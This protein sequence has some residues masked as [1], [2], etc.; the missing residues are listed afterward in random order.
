MIIFPFEFQQLPQYP[1]YY[2]NTADK[3]VYSIKSGSLK[4]IKATTYDPPSRLKLYKYQVQAH[5]KRW[6][7]SI[8]GVPYPLFM[9][10]I[11]MI[12]KKNDAVYFLKAL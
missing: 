1:G 7:L 5:E 2:F 12:M 4:P 8:K 6:T 9:T 3:K 11:K 10:E